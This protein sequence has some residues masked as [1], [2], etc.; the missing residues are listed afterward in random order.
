MF[1]IKIDWMNIDCL[2]IILA[3][4]QKDKYL[5]TNINYLKLFKVIYWI[6]KEYW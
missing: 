4:N 2:I 5:Q 6:I 1:L 3:K